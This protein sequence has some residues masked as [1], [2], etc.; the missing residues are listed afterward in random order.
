MAAKKS[1]GKKS[2]GRRYGKAAGMTVA[3]A[4]RRKKRGTLRSGK[5]GKGGKVKAGSRQSQSGSRKPAKR[6]QRFRPRNPAKLCGSAPQPVDAPGAASG[7]RQ[8]Q[9]H[10]AVEHSQLAHVEYWP[11]PAGRVLHEVGGHHLARE[12]EGHRPGEQAD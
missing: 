11:K 4:M 10:K 8:V 2:G 9:K 7:N 5:G 12:N 6:A 1:S 3:S